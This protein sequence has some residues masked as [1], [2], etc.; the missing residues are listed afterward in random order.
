ML[1]IE[2]NDELV[3]AFW[4]R[5]VGSLYELATPDRPFDAFL[6]IAS[7][8]ISNKLADDP[9]NVVESVTTPTG[10]TGEYAL[11]FCISGAL[12][13]DL[14]AAAKDFFGIASH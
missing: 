8:L 4:D 12:E 7:G 1:E 11:G 6:H 3:V 5:L 14:A 13:R 10:R 9:A 2:C